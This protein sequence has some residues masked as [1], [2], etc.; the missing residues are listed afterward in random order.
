[1]SAFLLAIALALAAAPRA[2][3]ESRGAAKE[4][5]KDAPAPAP[6][7]ADAPRADAQ[8]GSMGLLTSAPRKKGHAPQTTACAACHSPTSWSET[9]FNHQKTGFPL[10]GRHA[11]TGCKACHPV[12][13]QRS[14]PATCSGC[15]L[16]VHG[17][18]LGGRCEGCHDSLGWKSRFPADAHRLTGFPLVGRHAAL[19][20]GECHF[21]EAAGRFSRAATPCVACHQQ[22]YDATAGSS[23]DHAASG[24]STLCEQCH[25]AWTFRG[26]RFPGHDAC[27]VISQ[28]EHAGLACAQ[29]HSGF[30]RGLTPGSC[31]T[32][33]AICTSCHQH[34]CAKSDPQH[35][36]VLGYRCQDRR[37]AEC[38][39]QGRGGR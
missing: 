39:Q 24:F 10:L 18:E 31:S 11:T 36:G 27:F 9:R 32:G 38:H 23:L 13:F 8:P 22:D 5:K 14:V 12:D 34:E 37:C 1:M 20:C 35:Q 15:H 33:T 26:A 28:G 17:G 25:Q 16:D 6:P 3:R 2:P 4:Q 7:A 21:T 30:P 29:C 19:P